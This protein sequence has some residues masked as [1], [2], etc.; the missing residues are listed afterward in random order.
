M[1]RFRALA[2]LLLCLPLL[3]TRCVPAPEHSVT[4]A[5]GGL[6]H[7][8]GLAFTPGGQLIFTERD[9]GSVNVWLAPGDVREI[10][11]IPDV[12]ARGEGG[13][14]DV[15]VD[16]AFETNRRIYTCFAS[17]ARDVRVVRWRVAPDWSGLTDRADILTAIPYSTGRHSGCALELG[18]DGQLWIGTGDAATSG[19]QQDLRSLGGKVL[20]ID[21]EGNASVGNPFAGRADAD[22]RIYTYGHRNVQAIAF[23]PTTGFPY[24]VEHGPNR[25]DEVNVLLPGRNYGWAPGPGYDESVPMTDFRRF[26]DAVPA[27]WSSGSPTIAPSGATFVR[28]GTGWGHWEGGLAMAVLKG[29]ELRVLGLGAFGVVAETHS[30]ALTG[31][32][33]RVRNV[34]QGP[35]GALWVA[36]D[37]GDGAGVIWYVRPA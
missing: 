32:G 14:L 1:R 31:E 22:P 2:L 10:A 3:G 4:V 5:I 35:D 37:G 25:D 7:P 13:L 6:D 11:V 8:W 15:A 20:R 29:R 36:S 24:T 16:P 26:P 23:H 21:T 27:V 19:V 12:R 28:P 34:V 30:P 33:Q 18:P 17:D 9:E